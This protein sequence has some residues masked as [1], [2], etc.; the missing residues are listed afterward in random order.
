MNLLF[1]NPVIENR[2]RRTVNDAEG[3]IGGWFFTRCEPKTWPVKFSWRDTK[4]ALGSGLRFI[5]GILILPNQSDDPNNQWSSWDFMKA[6]EL[7][8]EMARFYDAYPLHFHTHPSGLRNPSWQDFAFAGA[9][10]QV[11]SRRAEFCVVTPAPLRLWGYS[12]QFGTPANPDSVY[13]V[14]MGQFFSWRMKS[15]KQL[16]K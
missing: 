1:S 5:E 9:H 14:E 16:V 8:D 10:C 4:K 6:R 7:A 15:V 12:V 13:G 3:E 2:F 11:W